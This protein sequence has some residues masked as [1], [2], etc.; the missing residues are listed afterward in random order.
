MEF[1]DCDMSDD[2][3]DDSEDLI[4][5]FPWLSK[6]RLTN[7]RPRMTHLCEQRVLLNASKK[8]VLCIKRPRVQNAALHGQFPSSLSVKDEHIACLLDLLESYSTDSTLRKLCKTLSNQCDKIWR[9][10]EFSKSD[11]VQCFYPLRSEINAVIADVTDATLLNVK[12]YLELRYA[13]KRNWLFHV[14]IEK[15]ERKSQETLRISWLVEQANAEGSKDWERTYWTG[16]DV[17]QPCDQRACQCPESDEAWDLD[18]WAVLLLARFDQ[19]RAICEAR[20]DEADA[21]SKA[22]QRKDE[23]EARRLLVES[24]KR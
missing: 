4:S 21:T 6:Q 23:D 9:I 24:F 15:T 20:W 2:E 1:F 22:R 16:I 19:K 18:K 11:K 12:R 3:M 17:T 7:L 8:D 5:T 14:E 10:P 13:N